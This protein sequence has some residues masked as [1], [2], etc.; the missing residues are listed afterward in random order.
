RVASHRCLAIDH[1]GHRARDTA[2]SER[3]E[4]PPA[5]RENPRSGTTPGGV[6][7]ESAGAP[8]SKFHPGSDV[9]KSATSRPGRGHQSQSSILSAPTDRA[10]LRQTHAGHSDSAIDYTES[11]DSRAES[12]LPR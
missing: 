12:A 2:R 10:P 4:Q 1:V 8:G 7:G 11:P 6:R 3:V 5:D 9:P